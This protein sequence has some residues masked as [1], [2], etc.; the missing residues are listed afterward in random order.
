VKRTVRVGGFVQCAEDFN[1]QAGVLNG[2]SDLFGAVFEERGVHVR[3][4]VGT[5]SLPLDVAVE[6]DC[7][8]EIED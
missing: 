6:V 5:N 8:I 4:A 3:T 1:M 2:C 7:I